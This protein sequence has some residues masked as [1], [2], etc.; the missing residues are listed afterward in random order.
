M[1][2]S[3]DIQISLD[4]FG[5]LS[6]DPV[7]HCW[8]KPPPGYLKLNVDGSFLDGH[9]SF[10]GILRDNDGTWIWGFAGA[11]PTADALE[12]E[13]MAIRT[14]LHVLL[15]KRISRVLIETDSSQAVNLFHGHPEDTHP[16]LL[17]IL[18]YKR[19]HTQLWSSPILYTPRTCNTCA[20]LLASLGRHSLVAGNIVWFPVIPAPLQGAV[21]S[22]MYI[23]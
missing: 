20:H 8:T 23:C 5:L 19:I 17:T 1:T 11:F 22:D 14:D 2:L 15:D 13:L 16:L 21:Q 10:G 7:N 18:D 9:A 3:T 4:K 12:A 6:I